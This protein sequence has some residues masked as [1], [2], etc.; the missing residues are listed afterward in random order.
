[1]SNLERKAEGKGLRYAVE[2][3]NPYQYD[4]LEIDCSWTIQIDRSWVTCSLDHAVVSKDSYAIVMSRKEHASQ[5][6]SE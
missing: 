2:K 1:M 3:D 6:R 4:C 5:S